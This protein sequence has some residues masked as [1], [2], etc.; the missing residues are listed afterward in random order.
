MSD[1]TEPADDAEVAEVA[2]R[3]AARWR[4]TL[5]LLAEGPR[6]C[7]DPACGGVVHD[8][9]TDRMLGMVCARC[10]THTGNYT[11]GHHWAI[12][13]VLIGRGVPWKE[14]KREYHFCCPGDCEL[15]ARP[16]VSDQG[17]EPS[18]VGHAAM[19]RTHG[20]VMPDAEVAAL[21][22][23]ASVIEPWPDDDV[24]YGTVTLAEQQEAVDWVLGQVGKPIEPVPCVTCGLTDCAHL[25]R[26]LADVGVVCSECRGGSCVNCTRDVLVYGGEGVRADT[27]EACQHRVDKVHP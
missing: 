5:D 15:E 11:Q 10:N 13:K 21:Y 4:P 7:I 20:R 16:P 1:P 19:P 14:A 17:A 9:D 24:P 23:E 3:A 8:L 25:V 6:P 2:A 22:A 12:C 26:V 27:L 18:S